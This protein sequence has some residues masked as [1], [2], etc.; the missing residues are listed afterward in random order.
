M[1][2]KVLNTI[3][4]SI[5][6]HLHGHYRVNWYCLTRWYINYSKKLLLKEKGTSLW[7]EKSTVPLLQFDMIQGLCFQQKSDT[8]YHRWLYPPCKNKKRT[9]KMWMEKRKTNIS[10][11]PSKTFLRN[12]INDEGGIPGFEAFAGET[13]MCSDFSESWAC[14]RAFNVSFVADETYNNNI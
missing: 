3:C 2:G 13:I 5:L 7:V 4:N 1:D 14:F 10:R 8:S 12:D 6:E 11:V 9:I